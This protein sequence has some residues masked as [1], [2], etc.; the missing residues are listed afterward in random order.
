MGKR[1]EMMRDGDVLQPHHINAIHRELNRWRGLRAVHPLQITGAEDGLSSPEISY[2]EQRPITIKLTA[3]GDA[4]GKHEW[5][6]VVWNG[7][8]FI[9]SSRSGDVNGDWA[10]EINGLRCPKSDEIYQAWR[11]NWGVWTFKAVRT[12][13]VASADINA[14]SSGT[15]YLW[16]LF[17]GAYTNSNT[18]ITAYNWNDTTKVTSGKRLMLT[19]H[20][21]RWLVDFEVC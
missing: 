11:N 14:N 2:A 18:S 21:S 7:T 12:L 6:G 1:F 8:A 9:N 4:N 13:A 20:A 15:V 17:N 3:T 19:P 10:M 5:Q 16:S